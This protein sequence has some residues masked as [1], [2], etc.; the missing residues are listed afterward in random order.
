MDI[1]SIPEEKFWIDKYTPRKFEE[2]DYND[3]VTEILKA[4]SS[5]DDFSHLIFYGPDGAGK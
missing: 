1:L 3:N 4:I 2:L 5:S